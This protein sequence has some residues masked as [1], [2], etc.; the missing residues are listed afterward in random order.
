MTDNAPPNSAPR[1]SRSLLKWGLRVLV[2]VAIL[3][4]LFS[5]GL[6]TPAGQRWAVQRA[7]R[8]LHGALFDEAGGHEIH[9]EGVALS[10]WPAGIRLTGIQWMGGQ[11]SLHVLAQLASLT[12]MPNGWSGTDWSSLDIQGLRYMPQRG[13]TPNLTC[14][15]TAS[16]TGEWKL[17]RLTLA[18]ITIEFTGQEQAGHSL[19]ALTAETG[20]V[21]GLALRG[22]RPGWQDFEATTALVMTPPAGSALTTVD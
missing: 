20:S 15:G 22:G 18:D 6:S 10:A 3:L 12:A 5:A 7:V 2:A 13:T 21:Q 16:D 17:N 19:S 4:V 11:D 8:A 14:R 9:V 1:G